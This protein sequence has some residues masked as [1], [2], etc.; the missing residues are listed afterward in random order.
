MR[1]EIEQIEHT[2]RSIDNHGENPGNIWCHVTR[3]TW[4]RV[5]AI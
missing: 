1:G 5:T 3:D 4:T 2:Q